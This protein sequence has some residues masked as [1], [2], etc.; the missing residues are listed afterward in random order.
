MPSGDHGYHIWELSRDFRV[1]RMLDRINRRETWDDPGIST[2][3]HFLTR[4]AATEYVRRNLKDRNTTVR[5]CAW[6]ACAFVHLSEFLEGRPPYE[7]ADVAE[8]K[9][10]EARAADARRRKRDAKRQADFARAV[11][12]EVERRLAAVPALQQLEP[13]DAGDNV[14]RGTIIAEL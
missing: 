5:A 3:G 7:L 2:P 4:S 12:A 14:P 1:W 10:G 9:R 13:A 11:A 6:P 8:R